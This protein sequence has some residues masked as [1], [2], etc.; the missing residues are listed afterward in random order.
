[1][2]KKQ[3]LQI[4]SSRSHGTVALS[5]SAKQQ[6]LTRSAA[7]P[8][9]SG[10]SKKL[11]RRLARPCKVQGCTASLRNTRNFFWATML[12]LLS[13]LVRLVVRLI[14]CW[15]LWEKC[16]SKTTLNH[17]FDL[18]IKTSLSLATEIELHNQESSLDQAQHCSNGQFATKI[19]VHS[20]SPS[21]DGKPDPQ[22]LASKALIH[23]CSTFKGSTF[24][25]IGCLPRTHTMQRTNLNMH[26]AW[27]STC[28][29]TAN[30]IP[31]ELVATKWIC[32]QLPSDYIAIWQNQ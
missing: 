7:G 18:E 9:S 21:P 31:E 8:R 20:C 16:T 10:C 23:Y 24:L 6:R 13:G 30:E 27:T 26:A 17:S 22:L 14:R 32:H 11:P 2:S 1:M 25:P 19:R 29:Y 4:C 3:R 15:Y 5:L 12:Y 28:N